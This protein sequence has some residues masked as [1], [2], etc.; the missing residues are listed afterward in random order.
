MWKYCERRWFWRTDV[1]PWPCLFGLHSKRMSN[2]QRYCRQLQE[3][4]RIQNLCWSYTEKLQSTGKLDANISSWSYD[5]EGH[6]KKSW[7]DIANWQTKQLNSYTKSQH[8]ALTTTNSRKKKWDLLEN[9]QKFAHRLFPNACIWP[10]LVDLIFYGPWTKLAR[11]ITKWTKACDKRLNRLISYIHHTCEYKQYCHVRN[12]AQQCR[13]GLFQD[14][15]FPRDLEDSKL[16]SGGVL[17]IFGCRR[18]VSMKWMCKK[19]TS[20]SHSST[21]AEIISLDADWRMD[22]IPALDLRDLVCEVFHSSPNRLNNTKGQWQ[23]N[24]SRNTTSNKYTQSKTKVPTQHDNLMWTMLAVCRR[25]RSFLD[26]VRCRT[27]WRTTKQWLKW[28]SKAWVPQWDMYPEPTE[29]LLIG[30][31]TELIWAP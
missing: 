2:K 17:C 28:S 19:Q 11:S 27:S 6:A 13:L 3:H 15:D 22:G 20:V 23:A 25:T 14:S 21:E 26:L 8:H 9:C 1:I 12:T 5:M 7:K 31:L 30:C 10:V 4:V 16:T 24:L 29:L 18:F